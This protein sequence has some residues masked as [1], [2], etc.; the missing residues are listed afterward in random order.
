ME[1]I[2][3]RMLLEPG[4]YE[5]MYVQS[6]SAERASEISWIKFCVEEP[7]DGLIGGFYLYGN[8]SEESLNTMLLTGAN[9]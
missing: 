6:L 4:A 1:D 2:V 8:R 9:M 3:S 5:V 7:Q